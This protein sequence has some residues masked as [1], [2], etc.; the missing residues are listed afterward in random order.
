MSVAPLG[1]VLQYSNFKEI[2]KMSVMTV[3]VPSSN[4]LY[5]NWYGCSL[6]SSFKNDT[7]TLKQYMCELIKCTNN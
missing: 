5:R 2:I 3:V 1:E 6:Y 7:V 4:T